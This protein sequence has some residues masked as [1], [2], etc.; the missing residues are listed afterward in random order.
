M[1]NCSTFVGLFFCVRLLRWLRYGVVAPLRGAPDDF[2][3]YDA[4]GFLLL[5]E[6]KL[7]DCCRSPSLLMIFYIGYMLSV[8]HVVADSFRIATLTELPPTG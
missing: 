6:H 4:S 3:L 1:K 5:A 8:A 7:T 2:S